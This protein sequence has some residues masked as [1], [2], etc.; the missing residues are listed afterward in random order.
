MIIAAAQRLAALSPALTD[1]DNPL[2]PDFA[3][4]YEVNYEVAV[5][6]AEQAIKDGVANVNWS[7][8]EVR[9]NAKEIR[10]E[11]EYGEYIYDE[12]GGK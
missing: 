2:L 7:D 8:E 9:K 3:D 10:W 11:A 1:P 6:V 12:K 4:A 5:A